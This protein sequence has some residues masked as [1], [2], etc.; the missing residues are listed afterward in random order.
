MFVL[1]KERVHLLD[2]EPFEN[3]FGKKAH[4]KKP[5]LNTCDMSE[6][7][8]QVNKRLDEYDETKD[9]NIVKDNE[10]TYDE[11]MYAL[12]KAGQSKRIWGELYKVRAFLQFYLQFCHNSLF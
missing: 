2:F 9:S 10:G 6:F 5:Q 11:A 3:T 12:F 4:R 8:Q 1:K 7:A